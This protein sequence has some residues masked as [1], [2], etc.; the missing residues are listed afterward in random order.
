MSPDG[1]AVVAEPFRLIGNAPVKR[2]EDADLGLSPAKHMIVHGS[3]L[4]IENKKEYVAD[5][6]PCDPIVRGGRLT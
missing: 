2:C 3:R 1:I 4:E 6:I 5:A